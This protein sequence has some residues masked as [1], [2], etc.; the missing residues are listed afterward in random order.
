MMG[1]ETMWNFVRKVA[2]QLAG[3]STL[4]IGNDGRRQLIREPDGSYVQMDL[5]A[6]RRHFEASSIA[7]FAEL[8]MANRG[9]FEK[10]YSKDECVLVD[11][12]GVTALHDAY[13]RVTVLWRPPTTKAFDRLLTCGPNITH[14]DLMRTFAVEWRGHVGVEVVE[15]FSRFHVITVDTKESEQRETRST[16]GRTIASELASELSGVGGT[17]VGP[18]PNG[19]AVVAAMLA[20]PNSPPFSIRVNSWFDFLKQE[21]VLRPDDADM[22]RAA[23]GATEWLAADVRTALI[24]LAGSDSMIPVVMGKVC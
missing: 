3:E 19:F 22:L 7:G 4:P 13:N 24:A 14:R 1:V 18:P 6:P 8:V 11:L 21:F 2:V 16:L 5:P 15:A 17:G 12:H 9:R 23:N 10:D 20:M